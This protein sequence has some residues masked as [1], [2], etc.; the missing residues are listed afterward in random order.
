VVLRRLES[1]DDEKTAR[2]KTE[3]V[4]RTRIA[5]E[6]DSRRGEYRYIK[7]VMVEGDIT[8]YQWAPDS[9][10]RYALI[11]PLESDE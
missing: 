5:I 11:Y 4:Q 9:G 10:L 3:Q 8:A 1:D 2:A 6:P 7:T